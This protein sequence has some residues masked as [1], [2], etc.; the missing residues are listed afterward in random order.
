MMPTMMVKIHPITSSVPLVRI[1]G[2]FQNRG[3]GV[4]NG[5]TVS[6]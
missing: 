1:E 6:N 5:G 3:W 4:P 2:R